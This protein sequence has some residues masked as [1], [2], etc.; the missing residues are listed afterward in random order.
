MKQIII[1]HGAPNE[2]EFF[3]VNEP[4]PS[5]MIWY[6]VI[7]KSL[8]LH[9]KLCQ[10]LEMPKSYDPMYHEWVAVFEQMKIS[11]ETILIGH[12]Y[13]GGFLL[14]YFS[15]HSEVIPKKLILVAPWIDPFKEL[16]D[17][18]LD[19]EINETLTG[20]FPVDIF[21]SSDD[22]ETGMQKTFEIIQE[23]LPNAQYHKFDNRE[24]FTETEFPELLEL[25]LKDA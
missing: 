5:N 24:H 15:E 19:F 21:L 16:T 25:V 1:I 14:K 11:N 18:F 10:V 20:R 3:D 6:P 7:Q 8:S 4:S 13:G 12:S 9:E 23:K 17:N 2:E 22:N